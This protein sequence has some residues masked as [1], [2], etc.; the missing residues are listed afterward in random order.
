MEKIKQMRGVS[1]KSATVS[2]MQEH[3]VV[4]NLAKVSPTENQAESARL[5]EAKKA[6]KKYHSSQPSTPKRNEHGKE[7]DRT[8]I[9]VP[10]GPKVT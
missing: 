7:D 2:E 4:I 3:E 8:L 5:H 9:K 6:V 1:E 10:R